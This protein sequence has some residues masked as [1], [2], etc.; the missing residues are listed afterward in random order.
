MSVSPKTRVPSQPRI[1]V[2]QVPQPPVEAYNSAKRKMDD[3]E[4]SVESQRRVSQP[5]SKPHVNGEYA[6]APPVVVASQPPA[7][8]RKRYAEPPIWARSVRAK[9]AGTF[10]GNR[11]LPTT[12]GKP[13]QNTLPPQPE[14]NGHHSPQS[15]R[16]APQISMDS[17]PSNLLGPWEDSIMGVKPTEELVRQVADFIFQ[18]V[19]SRPDLGELQSRGVDVE[20]EAKMGQFIESSS[21]QRISL[22]VLSE[23][24]MVERRQL[25]FRSAMTVVSPETVKYHVF[26]MDFTEPA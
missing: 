24:V 7:K 2:P 21:G 11:G 13:P 9:N 19:V 10:G 16:G 15:V 5:E 4:T 25:S 20:I 1:D 14:V 12:N 23:C 6:H 3:R 18:H 17:H 8:R 26:L 22:G